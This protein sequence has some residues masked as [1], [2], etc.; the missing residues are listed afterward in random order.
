MDQSENAYKAFFDGDDEAFVEIIRTHRDGLVY[1]INSLTRDMT[2]AEEL[3]EDT[4]FEL[5]VKR[6]KYLPSKG[7]FKTWLYAMGRNRAVNHLKRAA[8]VTLGEEA[9]EHL[10]DDETPP[11]AYVKEERASVIRKALCRIHPDYGTALYLSYF[12]G[13]DNG[14]IAQVMK[15]TKRRVEMLLYRGKQALKKELEKEGFVYEEL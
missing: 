12:E 11:L 3:A 9:M 8:R 1:F 2:L 14:G 7:S 10:T 5:L 4:L 15:V 13:L 6:P